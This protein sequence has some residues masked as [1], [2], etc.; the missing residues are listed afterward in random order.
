MKIYNIVNLFLFVFN[1]DRNLHGETQKSTAQIEIYREN[2]STTQKNFMK[3]NQ[4]QIVICIFR[5]RFDLTR[6]PKDF[7]VC[8]LLR[9]LSAVEF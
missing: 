1:K 7:S 6:F 9:Q 5:F 8:P 4:N 2:L 3:T